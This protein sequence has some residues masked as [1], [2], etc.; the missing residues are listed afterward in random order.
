[1]NFKIIGI[2]LFLTNTSFI[3]SQPSHFRYDLV[4]SQ[5]LNIRNSY[6][7]SLNS[8]LNDND[9]IKIDSLYTYTIN[10]D[11]NSKHFFTYDEQ[12]R[13][14]EWLSKSRNGNFWG[15]S[16][17]DKYFYDNEDNL[18][19]EL[20]FGW[21][22]AKW[23][24]LTRSTKTYND[25]QELSQSLFQFRE[26]DVWNNSNRS[27]FEYDNNSNQ[28][29]ATIEEWTG[30]E[31][32]NSMQINHYYYHSDYP[33]SIVFK[34][35]E[36]DRWNNFIK[37]L[38]HFHE[39]VTDLDSIIIFIWLESNWENYLLREIVEDDNDRQIDELD[40]IW[41][42][43]QWLFSAQRFF[44][45]YKESNLVSDASCRVW[46]SDHWKRGNSELLIELSKNIRIGFITHKI[47]VFHTDFVSDIENNLLKTNKYSLSQNY[48]NPFN[49]STTISF[50]LPKETQATLKV[51]DI[52]GNELIVLYD[53]YT[54]AGE[55]KIEFDAHNFTSGVYFYTL[56][57]SDFISTK[58]LLLVK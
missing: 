51:F 31:W 33:D 15:N 53:K 41:I 11:I 24:T 17:L 4:S 27:S 1:M 52:L 7:Y 54:N 32:I 12:N 48:P 57:T 42:N 16:T 34:L 37:T 25:T 40:N 26:L 55:Y 30:N 49:P 6:V 35:W 28:Y 50:T 56:K 21:D 2:I 43:G 36:Y 3:V 5:K 38:Y 23:D 47:K 18:I 20:N 8:F 39:D 29:L 10:N 44:D 58:K 46:E 13:I 22:N 14:T 45:Y 19:L 9:S